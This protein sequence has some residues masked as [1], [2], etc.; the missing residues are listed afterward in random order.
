MDNTSFIQSPREVLDYTFDFTDWL[1]GKTTIASAVVTPGT[2]IT[3]ASQS[4]TTTAVRIVVSGGTVNTKYK[5]K[6]KVTTAN[7]LQKESVM[8]IQIKEN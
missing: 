4:N 2:G 5:I 3:V 7:G 6:C 1:D 8:T